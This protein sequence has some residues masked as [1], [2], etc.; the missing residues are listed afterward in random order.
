MFRQVL[1]LPFSGPVPVERGKEAL[2]AIWLRNFGNSLRTRI[3]G[4]CPSTK[5]AS[6]RIE[7]NA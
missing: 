2:I 4:G 7:R 1:D 3:D 6:K 5:R